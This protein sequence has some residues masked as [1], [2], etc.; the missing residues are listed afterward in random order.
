MS[1]LCKNSL[2]SR[3]PLKVSGPRRPS[4]SPQTLQKWRG[5]IKDYEDSGQ[6]PTD[7]CRSQS[8]GSSSFYTWRKYFSQEAR[9]EKSPFIPLAVEDPRDPVEST[10]FEGCSLAHSASGEPSSSDPLMVHF[11]NGIRLEV[12]PHFH[13]PTLNRLIHVLSC[14]RG[15]DSC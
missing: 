13:A 9:Q 6:S 3:S 11:I 10:G 8:L 7:F 12:P 14:G 1:Q 15:K 4:P 2:V 5:I